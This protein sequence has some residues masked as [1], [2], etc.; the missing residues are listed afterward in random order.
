MS[1]QKP[2]RR[3]FRS[4][5]AA[6]DTTLAAPRDL[7]KITYQN[8]ECILA[9]WQ[10]IALCVW[11]NRA[12]VATVAELDKLVASLVAREAKVSAVHLAVRNSPL[13]TAETRAALQTFAERYSKHMAFSAI[14]LDVH[15]FWASA[16]RGFVTGLRALVGFDMQVKIFSTV[17]EL[18]AWMAPAHSSQTHVRVDSEELLRALVWLLREADSTHS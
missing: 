12:E 6:E 17:D 7:P 13:P 15:G 2:Q 1:S 16:I 11:T 9:S 8:D 5:P 10:N 4:H 3:S 14:L 18:V